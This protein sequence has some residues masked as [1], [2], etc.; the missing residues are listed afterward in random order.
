LQH[1]AAGDKKNQG[2]GDL[3]DNQRAAQ[4]GMTGARPAA[5]FVFQNVVDGG[6][7]SG[8]CRNQTEQQRGDQCYEA[9]KREHWKA[10]AG[11]A[12][13]GH[14][15]KLRFGNRGEQEGDSPFRGYES[16]RGSDKGKHQAFGQKLAGEI[17]SR[18]AE[19]GTNGEFLA[20]SNR[21]GK[22]QIGNVGAGD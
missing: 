11:G 13:V 5:G 17:G 14:G 12:Q 19:S 16:D 21:T 22:E 18:G 3:D 6:A 10:D 9:E 8:N 4:A 20:P 2:D 1:E 7:R 15:E